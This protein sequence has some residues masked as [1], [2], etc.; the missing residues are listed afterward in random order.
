VQAEGGAAAG[1]PWLPLALGGL[2]LLSLAAGAIP[3]HRALRRRAG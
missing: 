1:A 3:L 2:G